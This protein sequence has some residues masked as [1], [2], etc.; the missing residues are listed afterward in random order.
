M[1]SSYFQEIYL[2][3]DTGNSSICLRLG[4]VWGFLTGLFLVQPRCL[5][6]GF[7]SEQSL[8]AWS[9]VLTMCVFASG[10]LGSDW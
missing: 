4:L 1:Q 8:V 7:R 3:L 10:I 9:L 2:Y 5:E 6:V